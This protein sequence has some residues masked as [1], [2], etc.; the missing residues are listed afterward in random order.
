MSALMIYNNIINDIV[1]I[2]DILR[3]VNTSIKI[4]LFFMEGKIKKIKICGKYTS[5]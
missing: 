4:I 2:I 1:N 3:N 5:I